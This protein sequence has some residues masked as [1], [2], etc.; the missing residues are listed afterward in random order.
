M[1]RRDERHMR[2]PL[3]RLIRDGDVQSAAD[4]M[5]LVVGERDLRHVRQRIQRRA[6]ARCLVT[7]R[8][9]RLRIVHMERAGGDTPQCAEVRRTVDGARQIAGQRTH[10]RAA[11]AYDP[12]VARVAM[13]GEQ[14]PRL[15]RDVDRLE[16]EHHTGTRRLVGTL[17]ID[18]LCRVGWRHL[19]DDAGQRWQCRTHRR[20]VWRRRFADHGA[21]QV[22][23]VGLTAKLNRRVVDL[24]LARDV[25]QQSSRASG[26]QHEQP[27]GERI[28]RA[29]VANPLLAQ[30][31][32]GRQHGIM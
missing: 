26:Q 31:P 15:H 30:G 25:G 16:I 1:F 18:T 24:R 3:Q 7:Q 6:Q 8:T 20:F 17:P 27:G 4:A 2:G 11:P 21:E 10:I 22:L 19:R 12:H 29:G 32:T 14:L 9:H 5:H 13:P 28:E 23:G